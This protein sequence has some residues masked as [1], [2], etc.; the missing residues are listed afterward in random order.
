VSGRIVLVGESNPY[1]DEPY[2]ALY[3]TPEGASGWRLCC[4]ILGMERSAYL[5]TFDRVDL[6]RGPWRIR[7]AREAAARLT[8]SR[9]VLLGTKVAAAHGIAFVP[10]SIIEEDAGRRWLVWPHPSGRNTRMWTPEAIDLARRQIT[11][12]AGT[13]P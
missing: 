4:L 6:V 11:A 3:P 12:L 2:F 13:N 8:H 1:S 10:F 9:R 7:A 5:H